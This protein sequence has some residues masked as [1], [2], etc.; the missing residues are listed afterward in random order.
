MSL[1][2]GIHLGKRHIFRQATGTKK[3]SFTQAAILPVLHFQRSCSVLG[4]LSG[5]WDTRV[6]KRR[7]NEFSQVVLS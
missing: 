2:G 1:E 3:A 4:A 5:T 7:D 6:N